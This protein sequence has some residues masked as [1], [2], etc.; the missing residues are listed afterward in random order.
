MDLKDKTT[1]RLRQE[2]LWKKIGTGCGLVIIALLFA[3]DPNT[4]ITKANRFEYDAELLLVIA[5][6]GLMYAWNANRK[7]LNEELR[8]RDELE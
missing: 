4:T 7:K 6:A 1:E 8:S 5:T 2:L 3:R